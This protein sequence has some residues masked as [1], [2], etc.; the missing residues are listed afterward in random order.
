MKD[1]FGWTPLAWAMDSPG[2][3]VAVRILVEIGRVDI[4]QRDET[5][6]RPVLSWAA[7]EGYSD[8]VKYLLTTSNIKRDLADND[9]RTPLSYA[10]ASGGLDVVR[11]LVRAGAAD[12]RSVDSSGRTAADWARLNGQEAV[13]QELEALD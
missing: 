4:N 12:V 10:A 7:S 3:L 13:V 5:N 6:G 9:G 8:I 2:Y 11:I 1:K